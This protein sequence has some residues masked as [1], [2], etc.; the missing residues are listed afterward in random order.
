MI[1]ET[2]T[3]LV[4]MISYT[5]IIII[6]QSLIICNVS[7][8]DKDLKMGESFKSKTWNLKSLVM[9]TRNDPQKCHIW[10]KLI[11]PYHPDRVKNKSQLS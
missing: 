7:T 3:V 11:M 8:S 4:H 2:F 9:P 10:A 1:P 5:L 6:L